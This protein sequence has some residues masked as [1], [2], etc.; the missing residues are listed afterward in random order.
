M[1][2]MFSGRLET[3][4]GVFALSRMCSGVLFC[5]VVVV[6]MVCVGVSQG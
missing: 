4:D 1:P 5:G 3:E 6:A 2:T